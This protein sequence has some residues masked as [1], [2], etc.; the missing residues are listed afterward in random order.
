MNFIDPN[1]TSKSSARCLGAAKGEFST[2]IDSEDGSGSILSAHRTPP[3]VLRNLHRLVHEKCDRVDQP[4]T[5]HLSAQGRPDPKGRRG[6]IV[7]GV[8]TKL[9][10]NKT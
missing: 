4:V 5:E 2:G 9:R 6:L 8:Q 7:S 3:Q 10:K 1:A